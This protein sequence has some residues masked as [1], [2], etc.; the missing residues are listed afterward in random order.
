MPTAETDLAKLTTPSLLWEQFQ[1]EH[2]ATLARESANRSDSFFEDVAV[3]VAGEPVR[4]MVPDDLL[5]LDRLRNP[6]V[7]GGRLGDLTSADVQQFLWVLSPH[8]RGTLLD[9]W[10]LGRFRARMD[11]RHQDDQTFGN[12]V[13]EL[14]RYID[15][16]FQ[17]SPASNTKQ[18]DELREKEGFR[19]PI[20]A[21][22]LATILVPL[23][24][25]VGQS[26][27]FDGRPWQFTPLP[28]IFQ[29]LKVARFKTGAQETDDSPSR[30]HESAWLAA[31]NEARRNGVLVGESGIPGSRGLEHVTAQ[32]VRAARTGLN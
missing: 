10:R 15:G 27:P 24:T 4:L 26:D 8:R 6:L 7:C 9:A 11:K 22:F 3:T 5:T 31:V 20:G 28:R 18:A 13:D 14:I 29:Y 23:S 1:A 21:H 12:D 25:D 17:D 19:R 2:A 32:Q 16:I 30:V